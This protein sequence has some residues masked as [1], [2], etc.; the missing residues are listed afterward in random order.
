[1]TRRSYFG[2]LTVFHFLYIR[3]S[4]L[5]AISLRIYSPRSLP[6]KRKRSC[7][8]HVRVECVVFFSLPVK[9]AAPFPFHPQPASSGE[10]N[11]S[12]RNSTPPRCHFPNF[13]PDPCFL[14]RRSLHA[15]EIGGTGGGERE[16]NISWPL[17]NKRKRRRERKADGG[18]EL[19]TGSRRTGQTLPENSCEEQ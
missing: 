17:E 9:K 7:R 15:P 4:T 13:P 16:Q 8:D 1:M 19:V 14:A 6:K 5:I 2:C 3:W 12:V 11:S 18:R 10:V